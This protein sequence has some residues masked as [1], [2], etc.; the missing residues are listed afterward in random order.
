VTRPT[1][2]P[3]D[4]ETARG[5]PAHRTCA[6]MEVFFATA[7]EYPEYRVNQATIEGVTQAY[8]RAGA[9]ALRSGTITIP[10]VVHVVYRTAIENVSEEQIQSQIEVLNNDF[11]TGNVDIGDVPGPFSALVGNPDLRFDL[12]TVAPDG[13]AAT[14]VTR[15]RTTKTAFAASDNSVKLP[16]LGGVAP[17]DTSRYLNMWVCTLKDGVL[18]YAQFPGGPSHTD[19]V[20]IRNTAFGTTGS[21]RAPFNLGRT[22][23]HEIGHYLNLSHIWGEARIPTCSDSDYVNDTPNQFGPNA[24]TPAF[25][26]VSCSNGPHG[27]MFMN[28]MD[29]VDDVAMIMFSLNQVARMRATLSGPRSG[30]GS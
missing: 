30:L 10:V 16:K 25:P 1:H 15:T 19:G 20:V 8:M 28:Y 29:Y 18:G 7:E 23:T 12:A 13:S 2:Q 4:E 26:K 22:A 17:W 24:G 21:A 27:D 14:G 5:L 6:T 9:A 11:S 3:V